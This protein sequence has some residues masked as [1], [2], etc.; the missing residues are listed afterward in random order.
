MTGSWRAWF[1]RRTDT[2][3]LSV[4]FC[5]SPSAS[6]TG[7]CRASAVRSGRWAA[8]SGRPFIGLLLLNGG[9]LLRVV[10]EPAARMDYDGA[11]DAVLA[12]SG[13]T[14]LAAVLIIARQIWGRLRPRPP[15][16]TVGPDRAS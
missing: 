5:S 11:T 15:R 2:C 4:G 10:A 7:C 16:A 13:F 9:L 8:T 14:Q 1:A 12:V 3:F 6:A